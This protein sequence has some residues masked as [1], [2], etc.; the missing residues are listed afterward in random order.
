[1]SISRYPLPQ[2]TVKT[3]ES[4]RS[5]LEVEHISG[6]NHGLFFAKNEWPIWAA[7]NQ[8]QKLLLSL[9]L[10]MPTYKAWT[11]VCL[12]LLNSFIHSVRKE[13][14]KKYLSIYL[15]IQP[16]YPLSV[17]HPSPSVKIACQHHPSLHPFIH[18]NASSPASQR[19]YTNHPIQIF[20][21]LRITIS[22]EKEREISHIL[23]IARSQ[24]SSQISQTQLQPIHVTVPTLDPAANLDTIPSRRNEFCSKDASSTR[25][26]ISAADEMK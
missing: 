3:D 7:N 24:S 21:H 5:S 25:L 23:A 12:V 10:S 18:L 2:L 4:R 13:K 17:L 19:L 16:T 6:P 11:A 1:M 22:T 9:S 20:T 8:F 26:N 14:E 15:S